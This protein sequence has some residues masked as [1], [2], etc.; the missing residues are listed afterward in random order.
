MIFTTTS[1]LPLVCEWVCVFVCIH[2]LFESVFVFLFLFIFQ[3][4]WPDRIDLCAHVNASGPEQTALGQALSCITGHQ[5]EDRFLKSSE[6]IHVTCCSDMGKQNGERQ[7]RQIT[8]SL[9]HCKIRK[10]EVTV[11]TYCVWYWIST[12]RNAFITHSLLFKADPFLY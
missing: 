7:W 5:R 4:W 11:C 3:K 10:R 2:A 8:C 9:L 6:L 12:P 1:P